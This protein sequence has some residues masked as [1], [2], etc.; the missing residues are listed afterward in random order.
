M[1]STEIFH[2]HSSR[3]AA[4]A[5]EGAPREGCPLFG[6]AEVDAEAAGQAAQQLHHAQHKEDVRREVRDAQRLYRA[7]WRE[8]VHP[9]S[10]PADTSAAEGKRL[11]FSDTLSCAKLT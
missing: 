6:G 5:A 8:R 2:S 11:H 9:A 7:V 4:G 1:A 10:V 3:V